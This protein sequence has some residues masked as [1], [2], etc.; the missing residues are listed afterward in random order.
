MSI[1]RN[2]VSDPPTMNSGDGNIVL[3]Y[4]HVPRRAAE[5]VTDT[6]SGRWIGQGPKVD[7][8]E[9][10]LSARL[11]AQTLAVGSGTDA[12]HL[13]YLLAGIGPGDEVIVPLFTCTATN[14]PLLYLGA[15]IV[16]ADIDPFTMNVDPIDV[17]KKITPR[18]KAIVVVHYGGCVC[19][20]DAIKEIAESA[21]IPVIEDA[22]HAMGA[23]YK[24]VP[25]G[26]LSN[27]TMF[28]FQAIKTITT[29]D[30]GALSIR[31]QTQAELAK[32]LRW[33]GIDRSAKLGGTWENDISEV[34]YK[35]QMTDVA[36]SMGLAGLEELDEVLAIRRRNLTRYT[37]NLY[38]NNAVRMIGVN[39]PL[40]EHGAWLMTVAV[41]DRPVVESRLRDMGI[42]SGR[43]HYRN[44][45]YSIFRDSRG[46]FPVMDAMEDQYMVV[47]LHS[48]MGLEEVD[49]VCDALVSSAKASIDAPV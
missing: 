24:G 2:V 3:F 30:G 1:N 4:P 39:G 10:E 37:E 18:T 47:P 23:L 48:R 27:Y 21:G 33:F 14:I 42:E 20:M 41:V 5:Y 19:D 15:K 32:R 11:G 28:S 44:D 40:N 9:L 7:K 46:T 34:G 29:G 12:L 6:L 16:F 8:F 31:D 49:R 26:S 13:S 45:R 17:A 25:V 38:G 35:Y 22:A 36:A 43:V